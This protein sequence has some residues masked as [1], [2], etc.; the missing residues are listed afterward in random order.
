M[1]VWTIGYRQPRRAQARVARTSAM[2]GP[3]ARI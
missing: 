2:P 1:P 3:Y